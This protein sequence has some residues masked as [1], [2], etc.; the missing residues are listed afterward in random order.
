MRRSKSD[1]V[2]QTVTNAL[3][4]LEEFRYD[5]ELG[6]TAL[7][8][9]L[10]LHKN[11]VF[12][13]LATLEQMRFVEQCAENDRYRLGMAC[14][15]LG[16]AFTR[17]RLLTR[18]ARSVVEG[19]AHE[20][21]ETAHLGVLDRFEVVHLDGESA[22]DLIGT[23]VRTGERLPVHASALGKALLACGDPEEWERMDRE[24]IRGGAL[25]AATAATITDRDKF[26]EHLR[27]AAGLGFALDVEECAKGLCC[28]AA[29]VRRGHGRVTAALAGPA[30]VFRPGADDRDPRRVP[31]VKGAAQEL[32][33][34]LGAA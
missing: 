31:A 17:T 20:T 12:R 14:V 18:V 15:G 8:K 32:S 22:S 21:H 19:L 10:G 9:R 25:P 11:N 27:S 5:E 26:F 23:R 34:R 2:I 3:R 1:Y 28:V 30:P 29:P 4:L 16:Q 33:R 6:V 13:L 24:W 7:A